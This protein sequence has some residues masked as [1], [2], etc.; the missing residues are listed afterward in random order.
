M[1]AQGALNVL[2]DEIKLRS[3]ARGELAKIRASMLIEIDAGRLPRSILS[4]TVIE[5]VTKLGTAY[6]NLC[7]DFCNHHAE[8]LPPS[9]GAIRAGLRGDGFPV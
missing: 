1:D 9:K 4:P 7:V 3:V 6:L 8:Y 5:M 2:R